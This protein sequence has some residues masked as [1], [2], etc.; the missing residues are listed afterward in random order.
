[1]EVAL[2]I[3]NVFP[4]DHPAQLLTNWFMKTG[5]K[6][7][8]TVPLVLGSV[9]V[10]LGAC[11]RRTCY[12]TLGQLF[13]FDLSI[14]KEHK[15]VTAGPYRFVR[16][17]SYTGAI[18]VGI[19]ATLCHFSPGSW[20]VECSGLFPKGASGWTFGLCWTV[21]TVLSF[22]WLLRR[23]EREDEISLGWNGKHGPS[24]CPI[25]WYHTCISLP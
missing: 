23:I 8:V 19:G 22:A 25:G 1:M 13:T 11:L 2:A 7:E 20:L 21:Q 5:C 18:L 24:Q 15:L 17:P 4:K 3:A 9:M 12:A 10:V 14:R 6:P 16:H